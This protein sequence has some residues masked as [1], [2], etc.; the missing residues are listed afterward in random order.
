MMRDPVSG[1]FV[2]MYKNSRASWSDQDKQQV[3]VKGVVTDLEPV[4]WARR[5]ES[6]IGSTECH[7]AEAY[8]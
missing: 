5:S 4:R 7:C 6:N 1:W 8:V 3:H 2:P